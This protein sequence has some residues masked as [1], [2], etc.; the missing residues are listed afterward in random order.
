[1]ASFGEGAGEGAGRADHDCMGCALIVD[2]R[3]WGLLT[4]DALTPGQFAGIDLR[5]VQTFASIAA[6]TV[7]AA[8]RIGRLARALEEQRSRGAGLGSVRVVMR[9]G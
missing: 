1:M 8:D 3:P 6:A 4:L 9:D 5:D 2:G 7:S